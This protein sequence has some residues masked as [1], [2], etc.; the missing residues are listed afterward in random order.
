M[1][2]DTVTS[3]TNNKLSDNVGNLFNKNGSNSITPILGSTEFNLGFSENAVLSFIGNNKSIFDGA[4]WIDKVN[5]VSSLTRLLT[6]IHPVV[7]TLENIIETN[8]DK[9]YSL[10]PGDS[11]AVTIPI[12]I[13]FKMNALDNTQAGENFKYLNLNNS[14]DTVK[15]IKKVKFLLEN[16]AENRAFKF[17]LKFIINRNKV[18]AK[19]IDAYTEPYITRN[20]LR[21]E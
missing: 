17:T 16:E 15:H 19:K 8:A 11:N 10:S 13:Y 1:N 9:I 3:T 14:K 4:K 12:N 5:N 21:S 20:D 18:I 6:T 7:P 2:Y